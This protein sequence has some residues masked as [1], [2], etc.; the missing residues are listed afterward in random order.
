MLS[1]PCSCE[2][3]QYNL[4][5]EGRLLTWRYRP[6]D[7]WKK[8]RQRSVSHAILLLLVMI[9]ILFPNRAIG[10]L[11]S[12][13]ETSKLGSHIQLINESGSNVLQVEMG[14]GPSDVTLSRDARM[15][16]KRMADN[17]FGKP[18]EITP[19]SKKQKVKSIPMEEWSQTIQNMQQEPKEK[20][21]QRTK[22]VLPLQV[23]DP[24][25]KE[26][27][28]DIS[29][30]ESG[31]SGLSSSQKEITDLFGPPNLFKI[32]YLPL[33]EQGK[34]LVRYETWTY[35]QHSQEITFIGG[36]ILATR[37]IQRIANTDEKITYSGLRPES[38]DLE[39][40]LSQVAKIVGSSDFQR[41][42]SLIDGF[43]EE[44]IE[45]YLGENCLFYIQNGYL[46]YFETFAIGGSE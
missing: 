28:T 15:I 38:F 14:K 29:I 4:P 26:T 43:E 10:R 27:E 40:N 30:V 25:T 36:E 46:L 39:I 41:V 5:V 34:H 42:E 35:P 31:P 45:I 18:S 37:D 11:A 20:Q 3:M 32:A 33:G 16:N 6:G 17:S 44:G 22:G 24:E 19:I 8:I 23:K 9:L 12:N 13:S 21:E 2:S 1:D 7:K